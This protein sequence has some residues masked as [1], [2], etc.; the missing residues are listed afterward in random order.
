MRRA[1]PLTIEVLERRIVPASFG[2]P[3]PEADALTLSFAQDGTV[4]GSHPSTL[5]KTLDAIAPARVWQTEILR[6]F[7]TFAAAADVNVGLV[8]D[9]GQPFGVLGLKEGDPRFGDIRIGAYPMA[10]DVLAVANPYDP[11]VA[12]TY[13]GDIFFNSNYHFSIGPHPGAYDLFTVALHE[14]GHVLGLPD[15]SDPTS[16]MFES[17]LQARSGISSTDAANL[18]SLYG[19]RPD[20][21]GNDTFATATALNLTGPGGQAAPAL[22]Q[23]N[24]GSQDTNFYQIAVPAGATALDV[25]LKVAG[26]SFLVPRLQLFDSAGNLVGSTVAPDPLHGDLSLHLDGVAP[27]SVYYVQVAGAAPDVFGFGAYLLQVQPAGADLPAFASASGLGK[28][29][30][31]V[32]SYTIANQPLP[33][34]AQLLATTPGY[35][36]H[37]YYEAADT[38]APDATVHTYR[39]RSADVGP[40]MTNVMTVAVRSLDVNA[41]HYQVWVY[42]DQGHQLAATVLFDEA[43]R[44]EIRVPSVLSDHDYTIA[45][46]STE[47]KAAGATNLFDVVADFAR[48][49]GNQQTFVHDTLAAGQAEQTRLLQVNRSDQFHFDLSATDWGAATNSG[50]VMTIYDAAGRAL[51]QLAADSGATRA[52]D[53]F[54]AAGQYRVVFTR[55]QPAALGTAVL[56]ELTGTNVSDPLG[57]QIRDTTLTPVDSAEAPAALS[58]FF[59]Q[60]ASPGTAVPTIPAAPTAGDISHPTLPPPLTFNVPGVNLAPPVAALSGPGPVLVAPGVLTAPVGIGAIGA[61]E[62]EVKLPPTLRSV[63]LAMLPAVSEVQPASAIVPSPTVPEP[64]ASAEVAP[65]PPC[66]ARTPERAME[67]EAPTEGFSLPRGLGTVWAVS[68]SMAFVAWI[69]RPL[70]RRSRVLPVLQKS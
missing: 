66:A 4:A 5:F 15:S 13:V 16:A 69:L 51:F 70:R 24:L 42:D 44:L 64:H 39:I 9:G 19:P 48:D 20:D 12:N 55:T 68:L 53:V 17:F 62:A 56:F 63:Q 22:V 67:R 25:A 8:H 47:V 43:G 10:P 65:L 54:L 40:G 28:D 7:Q 2:V 52:G 38:L 27:G 23:G 50:V 46:R 37:T 21:A 60:T 33:G 35:V 61:A 59:L 1:Y 58:F 36:E 34:G 11:F 26:R 57:P 29:A 31:L 49:A 3:W 32:P 30:S 6:A 45:V 41:P 14:A 18:R